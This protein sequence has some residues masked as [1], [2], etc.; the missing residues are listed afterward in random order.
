MFPEG[1]TT[2][3]SSL[4]KFKKGAFLAECS[5]KPIVLNYSLESTVSPAYDVIELFPLACL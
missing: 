3:G 5:V 2:N 1:G 4:L